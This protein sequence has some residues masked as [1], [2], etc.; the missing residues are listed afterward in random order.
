[1]KN[2]DNGKLTIKEIAKRAGV[3]TGTVDRVLHN[4]GRVSK[5]TA[6]L[7]SNII[8]ES[9]F[10]LN[11][12]ASALAAKKSFQVACLLPHF[13]DN[14]PFWE[15]PY[16]GMLKAEEE[17]ENFGITFANHTFNLFDTKSYI[18]KV[19]EIISD[20]PDALVLA[21]TFAKESLNITP[22]LDKLGIPYMFINTDSEGH[23]NISFIGQDS[24]AGGY[25]AGRLMAL[26]LRSGGDCAIMHIRPNSSNYSALAERTKGFEKYF[27]DNNINN[28]LLS[29]EIDDIASTAINKQFENIFNNN[30]NLKGVFVPSSRVSVLADNINN[31]ILKNIDI[32]GFDTTPPNIASLRDNKVSFL[33]SQKSFSQGYKSVIAMCNYLLYNIKP[34][35]KMFSPILIVSKENVESMSG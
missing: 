20:K 27:S 4:R 11:L 34:P 33:I 25:T 8:E 17:M 16:K 28:K 26:C 30:E 29:Y 6:Q 9:N 12:I 14:N 24:F 35:K 10:K 32:I 31:S 3:S 23:N 7:I 2:Q 5:K 13:D 22:K 1:M 19:A 18:T 21:P 15:S